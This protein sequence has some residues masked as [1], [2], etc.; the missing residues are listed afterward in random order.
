MLYSEFCDAS[1]SAMMK[2]SRHNF[3]FPSRLNS[4]AWFFAVVLASAAAGFYVSARTPGLELFSQDWLMRARGSLPAPA[5]IV[6]VAIDEASIKRFGRFPWPRS[7]MARALDRLREARPRAIG[8][9]V[10][11]TDPS[12]AGDDASLGQAIKKA[13]NVTLAAQLTNDHGNERAVWLKP[14]PE[15]ESAAAGVGHVNVYTG[16]DGV[17]RT[18]L[19]RDADDGGDS[20]W[21]MAVELIRVGESL[22]PNAVIAF[23]NSVV[24]GT[25]RIPIPENRDELLIDSQ[26]TGYRKIDAAQMII[27][28]IGPA[29][30]FAPQTVSIADVIEGKIA[31]DR[32]RDRY[33]LIGATAASLG[34]RIASPMIHEIGAGGKIRSELTPGVEILANQIQTILQGRF[35]RAFPGWLA[36]LCASVVAATVILSAALSRGNFESLRQIAAALF[37]LAA[38]LTI[39]FWA[40]TRWLILPPV[41]PMLLSFATAAP[42]VLL[43]RSWS[44]SREIDA[45]IAEL[46]KAGDRLLGTAPPP[47]RSLRGVWPRGGTWKAREL[48][49]LNRRVVERALFVDRAFRA[50]DDGLVVATADAVIVFANPRAVEILGASERSLSGGNLF[51]RIAEAEASS[52]FQPLTLVSRMQSAEAARIQLERLIE[53]RKPMEREISFNRGAGNPRHY[54][55]RISTVSDDSAGAIYGLVASFTDIT[56]HRELE[57]T[58]RDVMAL[59]THE[60]KT[61]LTAI[62][63]MSEVLSQFDPDATERRQM[64]LTINDEAKRL[65]R[66]I[67]E[68]LDLTRLESGVHRPRFS[69]LRIE[70]VVER[71]LLMLDPLARQRNIRLDREFAQDLPATLGDVDLIGRAVTNLVSNAIKFSPRDAIVTVRTA[72]D[73]RFLRVEVI[74]RGGGIAAEYLPRIFEKFYRVPRVSDV[75]IP[76]TGLGLSLVEEVAD[77]H[78]GRVM[79]ESKPGAG[80]IF[81]LLLPYQ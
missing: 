34:E 12:N 53:N 73:E 56:R 20:F 25:H 46:Q 37:L 14:L 7:L 55:M 80:S 71:S 15:Y 47:S 5:E 64:H 2:E 39:S 10:L 18:L 72:A 22:G 68:Y 76:G 16:Y 54:A 74:D 43:R 61:P 19:L 11:Y 77:L 23:P 60:L 45:G 52:G 29:G 50:V 49:S 27:D 78:G 13:G 44:L 70:Q 67:D 65:A 26:G 41:L 38:I 17:A 58:Q 1:P 66:M 69:P 36:F 31:I 48:K 24:I 6:I 42:L 33:V 59:V 3:I 35:Y 8:L 79:V 75:D 51:E 63:G 62:Q 9:D 81:T 21:A 40:Y 30:A 32:F 57:R 4:L 28:Y